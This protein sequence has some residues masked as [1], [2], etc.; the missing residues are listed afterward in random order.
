MSET[1][2]E[3]VVVMKLSEIMLLSEHGYS[4]DEQLKISKGRNSPPSHVLVDRSESVLWPAI[5][6]QCQKGVD[7]T[8]MI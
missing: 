6:Q 2:R 3:M 1:D 4:M 5:P 7:D 8:H